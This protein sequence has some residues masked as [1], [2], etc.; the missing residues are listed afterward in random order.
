[1]VLFCAMV[2]AALAIP[3]PKKY[4]HESIEKDKK[5]ETLT[6]KERNFLREV[7]EKFGVKSDVPV[8]NQNKEEEEPV[9]KNDN[10]STDK[11]A[12]PAVI[13]IEIVNDTDS[14]SKG[15]RT[16]DANLGYGY[17]TNNGYSYS[18]FGKSNQDKGKFV[19]YP[20]SQED[21]PTYSNPENKYLPPSNGKY[22]SFQSTST[23][24]EIQPSQAYELV[25]VKDEQPS[26]EYKKP[27][28]EFKT[29]PNV[30]TDK[31][32]AQ[33]LYT[34]YN[35]QELSGLSGQF[36]TVMPNYFVDPSQLLQNPHYQ[37]A[38]LTQDHL[39]SQG[40]YLNQNQRIVPVLVLRVPSSYL[41]NPTAELYANLPRNY[42]LSQHLNSVNLQSLV[43]QYFKK[44]GYSFGPNVMSY[45]S[46]AP[47]VE[48]GPN[49][50]SRPYVK[51]SYTQA[52]YSGVQYSAVKPVMARYPT[53]YAQQQYSVSQPQSV[54]QTPTQQQYEY[55]YRYVPQTETKLQT[56]YVQPGYQQSPQEV[57][58]SDGYQDQQS[59]VQQHSNVEESLSTDEYRTQYTNSQEGKEDKEYESH[60]IPQPTEQPDVSQYVSANPDSENYAVNN[61]NVDYSNQQVS[62]EYPSVAIPSYSSSEYYTQNTGQ[63]NTVSVYPSKLIHTEQYQEPEA[64]EVSA[65]DYA[66]TRQNIADSG[67]S[68]LIS[69][70]YPSKDH[71]IAT[72]LPFTYKT[73][74]RPTH[75]SVQG[76]SYVTPMPT[77]KY[78]SKYKIMVPQTVFRNPNSEKISY[79]N[80]HTLPMHYTQVGIYPNSN[81]VSEYA[82]GSQYVSSVASKPSYTRNFHTHPKRMA[83]PDTRREASSARMSVKE[84]NERNNMKKSS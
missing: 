47:S 68:L 79:V 75:T 81:T 24:V 63:K 35:G 19:I 10:T 52:D 83:K 5:S 66:Y 26:Y 21:P 72:V 38:G 9:E 42:P 12:F 6:T 40:S 67:K 84:T 46:A 82:A 20:Y 54:Y 43:N 71:T 25:P 77:S 39:R 16:I 15:K 1:M 30:Y 8:D 76:V 56:Y 64:P 65:Q 44:Q 51:P 45:Q 4:K 13:A 18:Y 61:K 22:S 31:K 3:D 32:T 80:S 37:S 2:S 53:T 7:E 29:P 17:R 41:Q 48:S 78:Q 36:P 62:V 49:H 14:Q 70:N 74:N 59:V 69:E 34:T 73:A 57:A 28:V 23:K 58:V 11:K 60:N 55:Q 33:T 50:Y 27:D